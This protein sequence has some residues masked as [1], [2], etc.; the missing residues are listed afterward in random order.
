MKF[1]ASVLAIVFA[2]G[3]A[4]FA[5]RAQSTRRTLPP[6]EPP[7]PAPQDAAAT[8]PDASFPG[9]VSAGTRFVIQLDDS[10]DTKEDKSGKPFVAQTTE[11]LVTLDGRTLPPGAVI[12]G[13]IDKCES[14]HQVGRAR[15]WLTFDTIGSP[16]GRLPLVAGLIDAPGMHSVHVAYDHEGEIMAASS[17]KQ[18]AELAA[19]A[20]ALAG[21]ATGVASK[22]TRDAATGAAIGALTAFLITSGLGQDFTLPKETKLEIVLLR[23]LLLY[24]SDR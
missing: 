24:N 13:H 1:A 14:A 3:P 2:I 16:R 22:N 17:K 9:A 4:T 8:Q 6:P 7:A 5:L 15:M 10:L 23:P 21:A 18:D 19:A 20:G 11:P 12:H